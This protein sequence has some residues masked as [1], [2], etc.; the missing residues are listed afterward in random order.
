[1]MRPT[2]SAGPV[3]FVLFVVVAALL[4]F[5]LDPRG[6]V[7]RVAATALLFAASAQAWNIVGGL[8][9]QISLGHAGFFG[10]GAYTS[11]LIYLRVGVSPWIGLVAGAALAGIAAALLSLPTFRL[12]GHYFALATLAFAEVMR[13]VGN[14]WTGLTGAPM[15]TRS[16]VTLEVDSITVT[17]GGL[18]AVDGVSFAMGRGE[19]VG[20]I[21]PNGAGKTTLFNTLVGLQRVSAGQVLLDGEAVSG[22]KPHRIAARGMTKTFQNTALF[23]DVSVIDN[24]TTGALLRH[25]LA[26]ARSHA[27]MILDKLDLTKIAGAD[28]AD[29]TFPQKAL[30]EMARALA[31]E[32]RILLLDEVMAALT[33]SEM[34][35]VMGVI[36]ALRDEGLAFL[37]GRASHARDH[38]ALRPAPR[39]QL[40]PPDRA[41]H[42]IRSSQR[43][44]RD[45]GLSRLGRSPQRFCSCSRLRTSAP[46]TAARMCWNTCR[47]LYAPEK[48]CRFSAPTQQARPRCY[49]ASRATSARFRARL[50]SAVRS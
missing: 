36:R 2:F 34:D 48:P 40:R 24:V 15:T 45:R 20:L 14:S 22:M 23:P 5:G 38:G 19:I 42:A 32:P 7:L 10:I 18:K 13:V 43:S 6:H 16:A 44:R 17:F 25:N 1:M 26:A 35:E 41:G 50:C 9:N 47:L 37:V 46:P 4:P 3:L 28:V 27:A 33:N 21:G 39:R 31:T 30:V 49:A 12:K 8:A 11:T 29:L